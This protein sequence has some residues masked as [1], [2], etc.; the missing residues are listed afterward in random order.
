MARDTRE[1]A[2]FTGVRFPIRIGEQGQL[3]DGLVG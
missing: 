1:T 2:A 3:N